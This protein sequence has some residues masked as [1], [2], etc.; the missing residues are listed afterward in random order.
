MAQ[1]TAPVV[2][3]Y[4]PP[5]GPGAGRP[6]TPV[7]YAPSTQLAQIGP[8]SGVGG[9]VTSPNAN[10]GS[11]SGISPNPANNTTGSQTLAPVPLPNASTAPTT[12]LLPALGL[13]NAGSRP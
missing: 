4:D 12:G 3:L 9:T 6:A 10:K 1:D 8:G 13:P 2:R 7:Q 11:A 5:I